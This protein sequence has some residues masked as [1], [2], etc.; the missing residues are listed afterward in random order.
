MSINDLDS[1]L[2]SNSVQVTVRSDRATLRNAKGR[3]YGH[4][5][6][7]SIEFVA[8]VT[9]HTLFDIPADLHPIINTALAIYSN[10]AT[11]QT[12]QALLFAD[13]SI[14]V[15]GLTVGQTYTISG[16]YCVV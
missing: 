13:G 3:H 10:N 5:V 1:L 14:S 11:T 7:I 15:N 2:N 6:F 4:M 16:V 9:S 12:I 8:N